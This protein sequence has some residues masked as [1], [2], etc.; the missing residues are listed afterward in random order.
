[1]GFCGEGREEAGAL[2][3]LHKFATELQME[4]ILD[5]I[6]EIK[7]RET[8]WWLHRLPSAF[9]IASERCVLG[10]WLGVDLALTSSKNLCGWLAPASRMTSAVF[11][12]HSA[13]APFLWFVLHTHTQ[14]PSLL[15][16]PLSP[17]L[18]PFPT[19][20]KIY[21]RHSSVG[22]GMLNTEAECDCGRRLR[23]SLVLRQKKRKNR[24]KE[25]ERFCA[26]SPL[27]PPP[28]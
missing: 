11:P 25:L 4:P 9:L 20:Q 19:V 1:M 16:P 13:V 24:R 21:L 23:W 28:H 18:S 22:R 15:F 17:P 26:S 10:R 14:S 6:G 5:G 2:N 3:H 12:I 27:P 7:V 8:E